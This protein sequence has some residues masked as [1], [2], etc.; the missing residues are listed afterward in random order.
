MKADHV[1]VDVMKTPEKNSK[2]GQ[3]AMEYLTTYG[4][5]ILII[6]I[7]LAALIYMG[8]FNVMNKVPESC[9]FDPTLQCSSARLFATT[10]SGKVVL[11]EITVTPR[12]NG[13]IK[14]CGIEVRTGDTPQDVPDSCF[15]STTRPRVQSGNGIRINFPGTFDFRGSS[16]MNPPM[17]FSIINIDLGPLIEMLKSMTFKDG[18]TNTDL[19]NYKKGERFTGNVF[20][21][22]SLDGDTGKARIWRGEVS[23]TLQ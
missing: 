9:T 23:G 20:L 4:W 17:L 2:R 13:D 10:V 19:V 6:V 14:L 5:A 3:A 18:N 11:G 7:V 12:V 16:A 21:Y 15:T 1:E 8:V 22:Y